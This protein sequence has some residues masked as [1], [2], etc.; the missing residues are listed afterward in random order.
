LDVKVVATD[1]TVTARVA[2]V[3]HATT[4]VRT[5]VRRAVMAE[6]RATDVAAAVSV[7]IAPRVDPVANDLKPMAK[8]MIR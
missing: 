8:S 5:I 4:V 2:V 3:R 6:A 7:G 1:A